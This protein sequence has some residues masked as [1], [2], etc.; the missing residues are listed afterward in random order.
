MDASTET[1]DETVIDTVPIFE[2]RK[3]SVAQGAALKSGR[4]FYLASKK[5]ARE[6]K[7]LEKEADRLLYAEYK[8][9]R[10]QAPAPDATIS[11][12]ASIQAPPSSTV[13]NIMFV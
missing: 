9:S 13:R 6:Q 7:A 11:P 1:V 3:M 10:L 8:A 2:K 12:P 5:T 4:E